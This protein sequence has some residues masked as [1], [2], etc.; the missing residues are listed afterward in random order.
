MDDR[1]SDG[2]TALHRAAR[3]G[4]LEAARNLINQHQH[5][6][7]YGQAYVKVESKNFLKQTSLHLAAEYGHAEVA[8][9]LLSHSAEV[10][11]KD[12]SGRTALHWAALTG[13][14]DVA[15][16]LLSHSA[17]VNAK[18]SNQSLC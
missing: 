1:D 3:D 12:R 5:Q 11:A 8:E 10:D 14:R 4:N 18:T 2:L 6:Y 7:H 16:V 15:E 9:L 17:E 13:H